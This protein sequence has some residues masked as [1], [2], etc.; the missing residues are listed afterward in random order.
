MLDHRGG[1]CM[2][3]CDMTKGDA[4]CPSESVWQFDGMVGEC[5]LKCAGRSDC[6]SVY[7]CSPASSEANDKVSH[8]FCDG[9]P[10]TVGDGGGAD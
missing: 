3:N 9:A 7:V 1:Y 5:H 2:R 4:D 8:A 6:R 10:T